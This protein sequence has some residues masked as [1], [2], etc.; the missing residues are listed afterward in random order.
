MHYVSTRG[1]APAL[2]FSDVLMAGLAR[3]GG[4]YLP[5]AWPALG[6][7][8]IAA[9]A[10]RSYADV[11]FRIIRPYVAGSIADADLEAM[12]ARA[13]AAL[14]RPSRRAAPRPRRRALR[15]R[16]VPRPD[17]RLQGRRHAVAGAADG[18]CAGQARQ[19]TTIVGATSGDTGSAAIEA[20]RDRDNV[21]IF[22]LFP[23]GRVSPFQ[24]RQM[25]TV[26]AAN[27]HPIAIKGNFDDCQA[28][29]KAMFGNAAFRDRTSLSGVNSINFARVLGQIVYYFTAAVA[30][31]AP[32]KPRLVHR[33]DRKLRRHLRRL[34]RQAHGPADR[35]AGD[36]HQRQ[37]HPRP[38]ARNRALR[39][40]RRDRHDLAVDGHPGFVEFRAAA[41]R[42]LRP[43]RR[44]G[45]RADGKPRRDRRIRYRPRR[46][47]PRSAA[48]SPPA[49]PTR[50]RSR[51][52]IAETYTRDRLPRRPAHRRRP[53]RRRA[54]QV[55][56]A[57]RW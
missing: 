49:A 46:R 13:Y 17:A 4:L 29:V 18:P 55:T 6:K 15:A 8:E 44:G 11:A 34:R 9:L 30:L 5:D 20:F 37:R 28:I 54:L 53:R 56:R 16:A 36:R 41:V 39:G 27:V 7:A 32:D 51:Q 57:R 12:I 24:Q 2:D 45:P 26:A 19:R 38:H 42:G 23:E 35:Q 1:L 33:A 40:A 43:R 31:G 21:D 48:I 50:R 47:S 10:G 52:T 14:P 3:D 25:T 22:I